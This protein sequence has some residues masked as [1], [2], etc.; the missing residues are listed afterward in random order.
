M[1]PHQRFSRPVEF[2]RYDL[3]TPLW[4]KQAE[5]LREIATEKRV[6][7]RS[8]NG[9]GKTFVA[10]TAVI[11]WLMAH[12]RT[13]A[14]VVTTAPT[15]HQVR[16][17]LWREIRSLYFRNAALIGGKIGRTTLELSPRH[18][19]TGLST[20]SPERF[21][22]FHETNI[23]FVVDEASGVHEEVFEAIEG[24]MTSR[25]VRLLLIG[26]PTSLS[27]TFYRAFHQHRTQYKT[28]HISAFDTPNLRLPAHNQLPLLRE[29]A[30]GRVD[31]EGP[32]DPITPGPKR[33]GGSDLPGEDNT[34]AE[35][36]SNRAQGTSRE[37]RPATNRVVDPS[38]PQRNGQKPPG[39]FGYAPEKARVIQR[40]EGWNKTVIPGIVTPEWVDD[41]SMTWGV[42]STQYQVRVLGEFPTQSDD[43]LIPL[44]HI[45]AAISSQPAPAPAHRAQISRVPTE[46]EGPGDDV[47]R[48]SPSP[49]GRELEG[50]S[51]PAT[52]DH[53]NVGMHEL[54][55][56]TQ[57][58]QIGVDVARFGTDRTVIC[59]RQ[60]NHVI[61]LDQHQK[62]DTMRTTGL[63]V[64]AIAEYNPQAV[65][66]DEIGVGAG[67]V[68]RLHEL[69]YSMVEGVNVGNRATDPE[70][71]FN[72]RSELY[73]GLRARFEEQ[74]I[75][76]P[77]DED[78]IGQLASIRVEY[79]SRGQLKVEPKET[80]RR[81]SLPS[82]DKADALVLAFAPTPPATPY[83]LWT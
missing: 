40:Q 36:L 16:D 54:R 81:R 39:N 11:W 33:G 9:S 37:V 48:I 55:D 26:N 14:L 22:G 5:I 49:A 41:A 6:A 64:K 71:F 18:F 68:D 60:G 2:V 76:I 1:P 44:T 45:E 47:S 52:A 32:S 30:G 70:H 57:P 15:Q 79:T 78:L 75:H 43:T 65:R 28:I 73:D 7:V 3:K 12:A 77:H 27:G 23:L 35:T 24:S 34:D 19:A 74:T 4:G 67:V 80:M 8:C 63:I 59:V 56:R 10:A 38:S 72:L 13:S 31:K 83:R 51:D 58:V 69:N 66:I 21:Q 25:R 42:N 20:D 50:G 61:V 46:T 62:L 29:G 17:L 53:L 82:P